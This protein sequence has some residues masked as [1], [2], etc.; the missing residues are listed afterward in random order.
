MPELPEVEVLK[1]L[2]RKNPK[3]NNQKGKIIDGNLRY[4]V[5]KDLIPKLAG[6]NKTDRKKIEIFNFKNKF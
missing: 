1:G 6:K 2:Q 3:F 4:K 5:N